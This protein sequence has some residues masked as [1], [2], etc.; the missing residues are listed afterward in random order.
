MPLFIKHFSN[1][2]QSAVHLIPLPLEHYLQCPRHTHTWGRRSMDN[3]PSNYRNKAIE[4][5]YLA[6]GRK[7]IGT[8]GAWTHDLVEACTVPLD[9]TRSHYSVNKRLGVCHLMNL[10]ISH[11]IKLIDTKHNPM[12]FNS[13]TIR[14]RNFVPN[15]KQ[16]FKYISHH[17]FNSAPYW[18]TAKPWR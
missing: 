9:H 17:T 16:W 6:R 18:R 14:I 15:R 12:R 4:T 11:S 8:S 10:C 1:I 3:I 5:K 7:H 13:V 2:G